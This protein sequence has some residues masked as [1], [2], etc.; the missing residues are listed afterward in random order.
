MSK[1]L[2][3]DLDL[4]ISM[5]SDNARKW[6]ALGTKDG[7]SL[8]LNSA[9]RPVK[10]VRVGKKEVSALAFSGDGRLLAASAGPRVSIYD[11][12]TGRVKRSFDL[13]RVPAGAIVRK[14][15]FLED[16]R[17][18][19]VG[20]TYAT[21]PKSG[22]GFVR[23]YAP[24]GTKVLKDVPYNYMVWSAALDMRGNV[25]IGRK[26]LQLRRLADLAIVAK[27]EIDIP[28]YLPVQVAA[29]KNGFGVASGSGYVYSKDL[30][31]WDSIVLPDETEPPIFGD[32]LAS[33]DRE[34]LLFYGLKLA[35][36]PKIR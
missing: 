34:Q 36:Y 3:K 24:G 6:L 19:V 11:L 35:V 29:F 30:K 10:S 25:L 12:V 2:M 13:L 17:L 26:Q 5:A 16:G 20:G 15:I 14:I 9:F 7:R 23:L 22:N 27:S 18:L 33:P 4:P 28:E 8:I 1:L 31:K 32:V 21:A